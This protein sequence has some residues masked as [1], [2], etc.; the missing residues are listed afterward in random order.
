MQTVLFK[1]EMILNNRPQTIENA[2]ENALTPNHLLF[3]R[4]LSSASDQNT[5]IQIRVQNITAQGKKVN[6][7]INYFGSRWL[8]EYVV[9]L[10]ETHKQNFQNQHQQHI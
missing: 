4:T 6:R 10:R 5:P 8:K 2:L 1:V 7:I 3:G 9:N